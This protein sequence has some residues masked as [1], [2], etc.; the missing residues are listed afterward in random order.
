MKS[1]AVPIF[2]PATR[3]DR[4]LKAA[5]SGADAVIIDL[6][7]AVSQANKAEARCN[8]AHASALPVPV[9]VRINGEGTE[10]HQADLD[11]V[12][13]HGIA[14]ICVPK[15]EATDTLDRIAAQLG[16]DTGIIALIESAAGLEN[17][18]ALGLHQ[19][20]RQLAFGPADFFLDMDMPPS[21]EMTG[22]VLCRLAT[23]SRAAGK[24]RPLDGP[25]FATGNPQDLQRECRDAL[26]SGAGGKLCIHPSQP[27]KV[28]ECF[29]PGPDEIAWARRVVEAE[30][31][32]GAR[33]VDGQMVD[34]PVLARAEA[35]LKRIPPAQPREMEGAAR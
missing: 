14:R 22:H 1:F 28:L 8:L 13:I 3:P 7:D 16:P 34:A 4:F 12:R 18:Q 6:E 2:V 27:A 15:A 31:D 21:R 10:W 26:R 35:I 5:H 17:A 33:I 23:A 19:A 20:V 32:G 9:V 11:A 29:A 30:G 24:G 25:C